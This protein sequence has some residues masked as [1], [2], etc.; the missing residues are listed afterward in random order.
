MNPRLGSWDGDGDENWDRKS[1]RL[2]AQTIR[3]KNKPTTRFPVTD[4]RVT[5]VESYIVCDWGVS[6][7]FRRNVLKV[8][9]TVQSYDD[10]SS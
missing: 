1:R 4:G 3:N 9:G 2:T 8:T 6:Y 10:E 7:A 5:A